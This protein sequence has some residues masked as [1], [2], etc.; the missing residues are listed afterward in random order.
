MNGAKGI[1]AGAK[2]AAA[3]AGVSAF[4]S[5]ATAEILSRY[6]PSPQASGLLSGDAPPSRFL[7]TLLSK[8]LFEDAIVFLAYAL[9]R[10][11]A[12]WWGL[13]CVQSIT[14]PEPA[15]EIAAALSAVDTWIADPTDPNRR[16]AMPAAEK[17][18]YGTPAGCLA[19]SAFFSE[20]S[21]SPPDCPPVPVGEWFCARTVAAAVHLGSLANG[22]KDAAKTARGFADLGAEVASK[23]PPWEKS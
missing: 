5:T 14:P 11:E 7:K 13:R 16:A 20:G 21:M 23:P 15:P 8:E 12:V 10:R 1:A 2:E 4:D 19:L 18:T 17:A 9:P 6:E 3:A 22:P